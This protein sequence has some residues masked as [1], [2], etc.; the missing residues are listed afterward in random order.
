MKV[1]TVAIVRPS[2]DPWVASFSSEKKAKKFKKN[3]ETA[4]RDAGHADD[5]VLSIDS[6]DIDSDLYLDWIDERY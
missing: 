3:C 2:G 4:L 1:W 5:T 6:G